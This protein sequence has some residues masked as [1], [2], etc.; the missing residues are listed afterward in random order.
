MK[1]I[2]VILKEIRLKI[3]KIGSKR[4]NKKLKIKDFSIISNNCF[5]GIVY[6]H[7]NMEYNTPTVGLYLFPKE[8]IKFV[9]RFSYY[10]N[11][12]LDF[13]DAK[14]S[15]YYDV[16]CKRNQEKAIIGI[17]DD[18]EIVFLHYKTKEEVLEKWERRKNRLS[19]NIIF[20]FNDQN[21]AEY[22]D[23]KQF[24]KLPVENKICFTAKKY[25][26]LPST[27]QIKKYK[28]YNEVKEDYYSFYKYMN[29]YDYIYNCFGGKINEQK[30][31]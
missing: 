7:F 12:K 28:K 18:I 27:I 9:K 14:A 24:D 15:K 26:E 20:K 8:Y 30:E 17:L 16:L 5:A 19:K 11:L 3:N 1:N 31:K 23:I 29:F 25:N 6:Q 21:G 13:I 2:R 22:E 4:R 10:M